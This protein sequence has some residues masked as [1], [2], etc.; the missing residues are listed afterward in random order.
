[1]ILDRGGGG[2]GMNIGSEYYEKLLE[3][4]PSTAVIDAVTSSS[5]SKNEG[6]VAADIATKAGVSL[7]QAKKDLTALATLSRGDISVSSDGDLVYRFPNDLQN[8]L[9][10]NSAKYKALQ[11]FEKV[12]PTLFWGIR[13]SFGVALLASVVLIFSTIL[14]IQTSGGSSDDRDD[15]RDDRRGGGVYCPEMETYTIM[16]QLFDPVVRYV[17]KTR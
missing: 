13:V 3:K 6:Y 2:G 4:L 16:H 9:S 5:S 15:R 8:V 10:Q 7:E 17:G 11:T 1:M 14:F 12:W